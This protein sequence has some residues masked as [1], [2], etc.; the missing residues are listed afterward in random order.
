MWR[1]WTTWVILAGLA[2]WELWLYV[3]FG[4]GDFWV[5]HGDDPGADAAAAVSRLVVPT[6]AILGVLGVGAL[7]MWNWWRVRRRR[8]VSPLAALL[9]AG[10]LLPVPLFLLLLSL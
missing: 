4:Q 9:W 3:K 1:R 7:L 2:L 6:L 10:L 5:D 8:H